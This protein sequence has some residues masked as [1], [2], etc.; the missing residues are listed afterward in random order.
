LLKHPSELRDDFAAGVATTPPAAWRGIV[1]QL[2][3]RLGHPVTAV[4][5]QVQ[6][7]ISSIG[8]VLPELV[9]YPALVE[10][11][12]AA[13]S[14]QLGAQELGVSVSGSASSTA[15]AAAAA[16]AS[17][18]GRLSITERLRAEQPKMVEQLQQM[19]AELNRCTLLWE[20]LLAGVLTS[21]SSDVAA[22][23]GKLRVEA[24]RV[25]ANTKL[26]DSEKERIVC[27][28]YML[29]MAPVVSALEAHQ[30]TISAAAV[31]PHER[32]FQAT[33]GR[34]L[35]R[36]ITAFKTP[37]ASFDACWEPLRE[38]LK[39]LSAALHT[40]T[41]DLRRISPAL[42]SLRGSEVPMPGL[43]AAASPD[44]YVC[45]DHLGLEVQTLPTKTKP[46]KLMLVGSDGREYNYLLKGREDLHLDERILQLLAV[47]HR[48]R[49]PHR[50]SAT[51][52]GWRRALSRTGQRDAAY[53]PSHPVAAL[54]ARAAL[55]CLPSRSA[56]GA[57]PV[58]AGRDPSLLPVQ[59]V[60]SAR[61]GGRGDRGG[62][63][64]G[65]GGARCQGEHGQ[66]GCGQGGHG[67]GEG[68]YAEITV[69]L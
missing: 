18:A 13:A 69:Y 51:F 23:V 12:S 14:A 61:R 64:G 52:D 46:K 34:T 20:D 24:R 41:L 28:K 26:T 50:L 67:Q 54:H 32:A 56:L 3:A 48:D 68:G 31:T 65:Q 49:N 22:R 8:S 5:A 36:A 17:Q 58:G 66:G 55:R 63:G 62:G 19:I 38:L 1:P 29:I 9:L 59:G 37:Q 10:Q 40:P 35:Q 16:A 27:D 33:H 30:R 6:S 25:R 2:F 4:R 11:A 15:A 57:H 53:R 44:E 60:A 21:Q 45:I 39:E 47:V 43:T 7:L 42:A